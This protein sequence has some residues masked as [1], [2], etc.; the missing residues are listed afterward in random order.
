M[1]DYIEFSDKAS[2]LNGNWD[3]LECFDL[4]NLILLPWVN[5][6]LRLSD[7]KFIVNLQSTGSFMHDPQINFMSQVNS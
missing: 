2:L 6:N 7:N 4:E 1:I 5:Q 3:F